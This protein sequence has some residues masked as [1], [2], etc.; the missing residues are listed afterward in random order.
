MSLKSNS[1]YPKVKNF[2]Y[3]LQGEKEEIK[4]WNKQFELGKDI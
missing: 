3:L 1:I 2:N 4:V